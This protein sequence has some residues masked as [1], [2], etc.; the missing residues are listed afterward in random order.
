M[1]KTEEETKNIEIENNAKNFIKSI[2]PKSAEALTICSLKLN[3]LNN[4]IYFCKEVDDYYSLCVLFRSL[5]EHYFKHL[6]IYSR[7]LRENSDDVGIEYYGKLNGHEDLCALRSSILLNTKLTRERSIWNLGDNQNKKLDAVAQNFKINN[8]F[9]YLSNNIGKDEEVKIISRDFFNKYSYYYST[10]SSFV[11]GGPYAEKYMEMYSKNEDKRKKDIEYLASE[12][13]FLA[14]QALKNTSFFID[15][16]FDK[17]QE[18][19][20]T[21]TP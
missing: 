6:Y 9:S 11:H 10:L 17:K 1:E 21:E 7:A 20:T 19:S 12:A 13:S 5:L 18:N 3:Y 4:S 2:F 16:T 8:I 14:N 15:L